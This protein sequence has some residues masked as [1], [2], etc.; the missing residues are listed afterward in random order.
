MDRALAAVPGETDRDLVVEARGGGRV[1]FDRLMA[2][3][4]E[5]A[6]RIAVAILGHEA[7]ARDATQEAFVRAWRDLRALRE[8]D[9]FDAWFGRILINACRTAL[10][11]RSRWRVR[12]VSVADDLA[13]ESHASLDDRA[14]ELDTLERAFDRL[15]ADDRSLLVLHHLD[16]R[17]VAGIA[18][19]L[20]IPEG[21]VKSRLH[22][23]RGALA[24]ALEV[25]RR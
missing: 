3:R 22:A 1:A 13:L 9:R 16:R 24:R 23:A 8:V 10:R 18:A 19:A 7:D 2:E 25:E 21:T 14:A 17:S 20:S 6:F 12:Q 4:L 5:P 15:S 11:S